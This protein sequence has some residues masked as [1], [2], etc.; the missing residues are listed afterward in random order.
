M[1]HEPVLP[2]EG[3]VG[4]V[5]ERPAAQRHH[6]VVGLGRLV[7]HLGLKGPEVLFSVLGEDGRDGAPVVGRDQAIEVEK[8]LAQPRRGLG[9]HGRLAA[10]HEAGE[11]DAHGVELRIR[12]KE[13]GIS[14]MGTGP[15]RRGA[16]S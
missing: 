10:R 2:G 7:Q 9:A 4:V 15:E 16:R 13:F 12:G 14:Y 6:K 11:V 3:A 1:H 5:H 8:R